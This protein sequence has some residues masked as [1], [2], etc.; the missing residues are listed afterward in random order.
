M[1][2]ALSLVGILLLTL[3]PVVL[4][5]CAEKTAQTAGETTPSIG[6]CLLPAEPAGARGVTEVRKS[7]KNNEEVVLVGRIGGDANPWVEGVAAFLVADA[8][9]S[10]CNEKPGD[11]CPT[12]WDYC[13]DLERLKDGKVVVTLVDDQRRPLMAEVKTA[14]GLKE[15]QTV[16]VRGRAECDEAGKLI[17]VAAD[18]LFVREQQP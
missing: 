3:A 18:G 15:L 14:L 17:N 16:V 12:P 1:T 9:L 5:G 7:A 11:T 4:T 8:S 6:K 10:P 13:C 2:K